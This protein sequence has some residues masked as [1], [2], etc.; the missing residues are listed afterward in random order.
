MPLDATIAEKLHLLDGITSFD[1][2][3]ADPEKASR[4]LAFLN[5]GN[6][7]A[8]PA[9][10][11]HDE[12]IGS[13]AGEFSIRVYEPDAQPQRVLVWAHGG[14]FTGGTIDMPEGD[15]FSREICQRASAVVISVDYA[16]AG[17]GIGYPTLHRQV[18]A[19]FMWARAAAPRWSI[20]TDSVA[21]GGASAGANLV[22]GSVAE[23][24][25]TRSPLPAQLILAYPTAHRDLQVSA[26]VEKLTST[27]PPMLRFTPAVISSMYAAY[28]NGAV[29]APYL[30]MDNRSF[31]G[32]PPMTVIVDEYDDLRTSGEVLAARAHDDGVKTTLRLAPG[33]LHGHFNRTAAVPQVD[34][35]LAFVAEVL[36]D[37][38]RAAR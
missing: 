10:R 7:Y 38:A 32:F 4:L 34:D 2:A 26:E 19:A 30:A 9:V 33:M 6:E 15:F 24:I 25:D 12:S 18:T 37:G 29:D 16:V 14:G 23:S 27:L 28:A 17:A 11:H 1:E 13:D 5:D 22:L 3:F 36:A 8:P 20:S 21:L 31:V 35:D